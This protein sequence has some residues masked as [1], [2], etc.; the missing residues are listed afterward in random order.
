VQGEEAVLAQ[1]TPTLGVFLLPVQ[2]LVR[3]LA[4]ALVAGLLVLRLV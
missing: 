1:A 3:V 2:F 4:Q